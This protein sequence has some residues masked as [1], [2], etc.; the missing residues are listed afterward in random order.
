MTEKNEGRPGQDGQNT[1]QI[2][3]L[4]AE[5]FLQALDPSG[6]FTFQ[7][8]PDRS[9]DSSLTRV[10]NGTFKQ[11]R[12]ELARLN[13]E[14][15]G[16]FVTVARTDDQGRKTENIIGIRAL[17]L[18]LDGT[19]LPNEWP[20]EP[21]FI[22][23]SSPGRFHV[24]WLVSDGFPLHQIEA[25][26]KAIAERFG[27]D[28]SVNDLPRVMRL[29]GF[30]HRKKEPFLTRIIRDWGDEPRY[31]TE[32]ILAA[33]S[34]VFGAKKTTIITDDPVLK[35]LES[36]GMII[37]GDRSE[38]GK[39][40]V[41][42]PWADQHTNCDEE[43]AYWSPHHGG[44]KGPGFKCLHSHCAERTAKD[45][46]EWLG[47]QGK[48][49]ADEGSFDLV[50]VSDLWDSQDEETAWA[51]EKLLPEGCVG[52]FGSQ[53]KAGKSTL[54]RCLAVSVASGRL[55]LGELDV[56]R[57]EVIYLALEENR[58]TVVR[59]F[60]TV[61]MRGFGMS[62]AEARETLSRIGLV[63]G[64]TPK[65]FEE[66]MAAL[67][68]RHRPVLVIVDTMIRLLK[69]QDSNAYSETST[70]LEPLLHLAHD[71]NVTVLLLHHTK[72]SDQGDLLGS[73]GIA[74]SADVV[75]TLGKKEGTRTLQAEGRG[76]SFEPTTL[77]FDTSGLAYSLGVPVEEAEIHAMAERIREFIGTHDTGNG[78][79]W[80]DIHSGVEGRK[81]TKNE[82]IKKLEIGEIIERRGTPHSRKDPL[83]YVLVPL[84]P[85][86]TQE[87]RDQHGK[88][89]SSP[90]R[91]LVPED[92]GSLDI[93]DNL[94][95][96]H[97]EIEWEEVD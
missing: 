71:R 61:A 88:K 27:G 19:P 17:F 30:L 40:I 93:A 48:A 38:K 76:V 39:Y 82:A 2:D 73:T 60:K 31:S 54:A 21:H 24:Y 74:A 34:P 51:V 47:I 64:P 62:E 92:V 80:K 55:F 87:P 85:S 14:G 77:T 70:G 65:K 89:S 45:L 59:Q 97:E 11:H 79:F 78:V 67:I 43:A 69:L 37:R 58:R 35:I 42:C 28:P 13:R 20:I 25:I 16:V 68:A 86:N 12:G 41:R 90:S 94:G 95:N 57:G 84:V 53:P 50:R 81:R 29:P 23:E 56:I 96:Q 33:F 9:K 63:C 26:Q 1:Q 91:I 72:K 46:F 66:K 15:A 22:F 3:F 32:R 18:D 52:I 6:T 5:A 49:K 36:K 44:F 75:I 7:T 10:L 83:R 4:M 8:F